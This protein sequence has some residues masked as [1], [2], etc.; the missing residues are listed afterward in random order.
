MACPVLSVNV[1]T[2]NA[3]ADVRQRL[4]NS[5]DCPLRDPEVTGTGRAN[6]TEVDKTM[7]RGHLTPSLHR[8]L[9]KRAG[10]GRSRRTGSGRVQAYANVS[11]SA[12]RPERQVSGK[13][14]DGGKTRSRPE[15]EVSGARTMAPKQPDRWRSEARL[16]RAP[17]SST[18]TFQFP[19]RH[20]RHVAPATAPPPLRGK[21]STCQCGR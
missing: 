17:S 3:A 14:I 19:M 13:A 11:Y 4:R 12:G 7:V 6:P 9:A 20:R 5:T 21:S 15:A 18:K 2:A 8:T 1:D 16:C 10:S